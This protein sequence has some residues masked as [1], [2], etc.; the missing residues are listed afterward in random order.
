MDRSPKQDALPARLAMLALLA[1]ALPR[2]G[3]SASD[4]LSAESDW[5]QG[6][7]FEQIDAELHRWFAE[8]PR[9]ERVAAS[10]GSA[11]EAAPRAARLAEPLRLIA[12]EADER[13][14][15]LLSNPSSQPPA[16]LLES[17]QAVNA[18]LRL[19]VADEL[20]ARAEYDACLAWTDG[21]TD[22]PVFSPS[23]LHYLRAVS[24]HQTVS[25]EEAGVEIE[26]LA[27]C[28]EATPSGKLG[29]ARRWVVEALSRELERENRPLPVVAR[30]M[31]DVERRLALAQAGEPTVERHETILKELDELIDKLEEQR[32]QQQQQAS[33]SAQAGGASPGEPAEES[34]PSELKG[35]G[36]VD[37]KRLVAGDAWGSLPPAER[38]RLTQAITRDFPPHYRSL[39]ED[40]FRTLAA[41][42][43]VAQPASPD[44]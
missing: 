2:I 38:A 5:R 36:E 6:D 31:R 39:V 14:A 43:D 16:W 4:G 35:P 34:R 9:G 17:E 26:R 32:K 30:R 37:R 23:L 27:A 3:L 28:E 13:F 1:M 7:R 12:A 44:E 8:S 33:Q 41:E 22:G 25:D 21:L 40:Y 29:P 18:S 11:V 19:A 15:S 10:W 42:A 20:A 24:F